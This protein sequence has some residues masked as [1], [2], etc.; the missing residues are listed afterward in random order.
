MKCW[1]VSHWP[2]V[3]FIKFLFFGSFLFY[4][5]TTYA[6]FFSLD[7]IPLSLFCFLSGVAGA[8]VFIICASLVFVRLSVCLSGSLEAL[9]SALFIHC[10]WSTFLGSSGSRTQLE[11]GRGNW[12]KL[13]TLQR[14]SRNFA[15]KFA[16]KCI[17]GITIG[18][19]TTVFYL[20]TV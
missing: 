19:N 16:F 15:F 7:F 6:L 5:S 4:L 9:E 20:F 1:T 18:K 11:Q 2:I 12:H 14:Q 8:A 10:F 13:D 3:N 17:Q